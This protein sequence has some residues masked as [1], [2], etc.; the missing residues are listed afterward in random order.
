MDFILS[1]SV[2]CRELSL[3]RK[4]CFLA[5]HYVKQRVPCGFMDSGVICKED[6][7]K[8]FNPFLFPTLGQGNQCS[9]N[10]FMSSFNHSICFRVICRNLNSSNTIFLKALND[11]PFE[12]SSSIYLYFTKDSMLVDNIFLDKLGNFSRHQCTYQLSFY[13]S[14]KVILNNNKAL[15]PVI[16]REIY[17]VNSQRIKQR[18][19]FY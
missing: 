6:S 15:V 8:V 10:R 12:F 4:H 19:S 13:L 1:Q 14:R 17:H 18:D 9:N 5:I 11:S 2:L 7:S 3:N 16:I